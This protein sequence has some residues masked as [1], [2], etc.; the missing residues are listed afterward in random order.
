M[1]IVM[2]LCIT[3]VHRARVGTYNKIIYLLQYLNFTGRY[4][5]NITWYLYLTPL[6]AGKFLEK[7]FDTLDSVQ[8]FLIY[9]IFN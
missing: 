3:I 7:F 2:E 4:Q 5:V 8:L 9:I 6:C 1:I